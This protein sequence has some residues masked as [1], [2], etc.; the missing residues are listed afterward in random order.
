[1]TRS[2][3]IIHELLVRYQFCIILRIPLYTA[4]VYEYAYT[5]VWYYIMISYF[6]QYIIMY[7]HDTKTKYFEVLYYTAQQGSSK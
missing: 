6:Q 7:I 5:C 3:V 4:A 1:M 2:I